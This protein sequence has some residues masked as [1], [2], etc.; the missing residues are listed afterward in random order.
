MAAETRSGRG[1]GPSL[2]VALLIGGTV[3]VVA[4]GIA[5]AA[6]G[7]FAQVVGLLSSLGVGAVLCVAGAAKAA[8]LRRWRSESATLGV[9]WLAAVA[10]PIVELAIGALSIVGVGWPIVPLAA[11]LLFV[12][13]SAV[14]VREL[15]GGR[16]PRCSCFGAWSSVPMS[17]WTVVRNGTLV[18]LAV[19]SLL[20]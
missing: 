9:P 15:W 2:G 20:R 11:G 14:V 13:F 1:E 18:A 6:S 19:V 7:R 4:V 5:L 3:V 16:H 12:A 10:V 8:D 17:G